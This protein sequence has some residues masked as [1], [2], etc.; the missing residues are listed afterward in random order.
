M[1]KK[2][3]SEQFIYAIRIAA[4][5]ELEEFQAILLATPDRVRKEPRIDSKIRGTMVSGDREEPPAQEGR[6]RCYQSGKL[7]LD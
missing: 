3:E 1:S 2:C 5:R 6:T 4:L 7:L